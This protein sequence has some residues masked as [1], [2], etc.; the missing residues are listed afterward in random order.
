MRRALPLLVVLAACGGT[1]PP[2]PPDPTLDRLSRAALL[3]WRQDRPEQASELFQQALTRAYARDEA[4]PIADNAT[5]LAAAQLRLGQS[6]PARATAAQARADLAR[7]GAA[8][9]DALTLAE[10]AALWRLGNGAGAVTLTRAITT[11]DGAPRARFIE[12]LVAADARDAA[13]LDTARAAIPDGPDFDSRADRAELDGRRALF[14]GDTTSARA[15]FAAAAAARQEVRDYPGMARALALEAEAA[16]AMGDG[17][18]AGDLWLRAGRSAA[19]EGNARDARTWLTAAEA[20]GRAAGDAALAR[21]AREALTALAA[22]QA[23]RAPAP[24]TR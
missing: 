13:A 15:R 21:G 24:L 10:A 1:I 18:A 8:I 9:P 12:G 6:E 20:A 5:G 3:A 19:A 11:G 14:S 2:D 7:R 22:D 17:R 4:G 23:L 16:R